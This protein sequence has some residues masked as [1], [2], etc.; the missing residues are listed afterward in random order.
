M[1]QKLPEIQG[2]KPDSKEEV[3]VAQA[4]YKYDEPFVFQYA[5]LGGIDMRGGLIIDFLLTRFM[6]P[7]EV[8]GDYW[9]EDEISG[10]EIL[11]LA[12]LKEIFG[13]EPLVILGSKAET[14]QMVERWVRR[15]VAS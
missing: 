15:N 5:V 11:R 9:H 1:A 13:T 2:K 14:P 12:K 3:W 10:D 4:L 8:Y 6:T 7:L